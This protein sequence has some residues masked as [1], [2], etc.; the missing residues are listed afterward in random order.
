LKERDT[1]ANPNAVLGRNTNENDYG[2]NE[3]SVQHRNWRAEDGKENK[4]NMYD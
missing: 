4:I 1:W 2:M 3:H